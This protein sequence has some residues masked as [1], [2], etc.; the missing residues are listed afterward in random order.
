MAAWC[1]LS[2]SCRPQ[3]FLWFRADA[4][5]AAIDAT[6]AAMPREI[7][8]AGRVGKAVTVNEDAAIKNEDDENV[9]EDDDANA[10]GASV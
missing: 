10:R 7:L 2:L 3:W 9:N 4:A 1:Q 5:D 6:D 8:Y